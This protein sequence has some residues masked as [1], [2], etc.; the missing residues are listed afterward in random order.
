MAS[1]TNQYL[2]KKQQHHHKLPPISS[3]Q[4]SFV[5]LFVLPIDRLSLTPWTF[6]TCHQISNANL[7]SHQKCMKT[8]KP[9]KLKVLKL[10]SLGYP[11]NPIQY[12]DFLSYVGGLGWEKRNWAENEHDFPSFLSWLH[13]S[14][15]LLLNP[16]IP[17]RLRRLLYVLF[18][19]YIIPFFLLKRHKK[20]SPLALCFHLIS[21]IHTHTLPGSAILC[22]FQIEAM[23][24]TNFLYLR[25]IHPSAPICTF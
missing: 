13:S 18:P 21:H 22:E 2:L 9:T 1:W 4:M 20:E 16:Q 19:P 12:E 15:Y 14:I 11:S 17:V 10:T 24:L 3:S 23:K 7:S 6:S 5:H 25:W 8:S